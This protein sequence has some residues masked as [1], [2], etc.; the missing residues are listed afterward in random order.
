M[1]LFLGLLP[2]QMTQLKDVWYSVH[3][4]LGPTLKILLLLVS[5]DV[6]TIHSVRTQRDNACRIVH[7]GVHM[8]IT[9][10]HFVW[11]FV[12]KIH[13]LKMHPCVV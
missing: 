2:L 7:I 12:L 3:L 5:S 8:L 1:Y 10:L 9:Q 6:L 11:Q 13:L 4:L